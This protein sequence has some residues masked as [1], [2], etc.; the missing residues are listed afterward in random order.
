MSGVRLNLYETRRGCERG[1]RLNDYVKQ[2]RVETEV[3]RE[4]SGRDMIPLR[5][6]R[7]PFHLRWAKLDLDFAL[8]AA[9]IACLYKTIVGGTRMWNS[10]VVV[11]VSQEGQDLHNYPLT[12]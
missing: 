11:V 8:C 9:L 1:G 6:R 12:I 3:A 2:R 10:P 5:G 7:N 4:L